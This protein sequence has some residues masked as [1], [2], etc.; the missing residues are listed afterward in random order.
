MEDGVGPPIRQ[1]LVL[2]E[3]VDDDQRE[4]VDMAIGEE[5]RDAVDGGRSR[6]VA[7][8]RR[9]RQMVEKQRRLGVAR[10]DLVRVVRP[11][12]HQ[13]P[14]LVQQRDGAVL[15]DVERV[16]EALEEAGIH[17]RQHDA[18]EHALRVAHGA[19]H[20]D[21]RL[22]RIAA[23]EGRADIAPR[24]RIVAMNGEIRPVRIVAMGRQGM[25]RRHPPAAGGVEHDDLA[26]LRELHGALGHPLVQPGHLDGIVDRVLGHQPPCEAG[27][28]EIDLREGQ[29]GMLRQRA[30]RILGGDA[31]LVELDVAR[32]PGAPAVHADEGQAD[33]DDETHRRRLARPP[34][35]TQISRT[36]FACPKH[37]SL[38]RRRR[39]SHTE[40]ASLTW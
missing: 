9:R 25:E 7:A 4:R 22:P 21:R 18:A 6:P 17:R 35:R 24:L 29:L 1:E 34:P 32:M 28:H 8:A 3:G 31:R 23:D 38:P 26:D 2:G 39:A 13:R 5:P 10:A 14:V 16:V 12:H 33:E 37:H 20:H 19:A 30:R 11:A 36:R 40:R 15:A 27:Q